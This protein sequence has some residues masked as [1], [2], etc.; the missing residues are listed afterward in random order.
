MKKAFQFLPFALPL[1]ILAIV[2]VI[3]F[4]VHNNN[5]E[6]TRHVIYH[7]EYDI[8]LQ[9]QGL[10]ELKEHLRKRRQGLNELKEH[11]RKRRHKMKCRLRKSFNVSYIGID[12]V[13]FFRENMRTNCSY[14][15]FHEKSENK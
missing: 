11:L 6:E 12:E 15:I 10:H 1:P 4:S 2:L 5:N 7:Y 8:D 13:S 14:S 3:I 9:K